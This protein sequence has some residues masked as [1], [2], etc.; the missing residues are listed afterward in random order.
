MP[1]CADTSANDEVTPRC[2]TG[3]PAAAGTDDGRRHARHHLDRNAGG[4]A[5]EGLLAAAAEDERVAALEA[6]DVEPA[7]RAF[8]DD[9]VDLVLRE[10]VVR[11]ASCRSR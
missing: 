10:H 4:V 9:L 5:G 2:V 3:M 8:D 11:P 6:D 1:S 7:Q